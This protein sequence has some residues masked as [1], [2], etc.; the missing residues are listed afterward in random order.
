MKS[1]KV[2]VEWAKN[3]L[4]NHELIHIKTVANTDYSF[5][6]EMQCKNFCFFLKKNHMLF[7]YEHKLLSYLYLNQTNSLNVYDYNKD[8]NCFITEYNGIQIT[9]NILD[10][11]RQII[12]RFIDI[13]IKSKK[14]ELK[15]LGLR[16]FM[17]AE[18]LNLCNKYQV[19]S[20]NLLKCW[21]E[22]EKVIPLSL[23]HGDFHLGNI[24]L[25]KNDRITFI[26]LA[27]G[28]ITNPLFSLLAFENTLK[29]RGNLNEVIIDDARNYWIKK[30]SQK[31]QLDIDIV[32]KM[33]L[34]SKE[35]FPLYCIFGLDFLLKTCSDEQFKAKTN[36]KISNYKKLLLNHSV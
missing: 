21:N 14:I 18:I 10:Y 35:I 20:H 4:K 36:M 15:E 29:W 34:Y 31:I 8:L 17:E 6:A 22:I 27:E 3:I 19:K 12:D 33:Y 13:Q 11:Y 30:Y 24:L 25:D 5:V 1:I 2:E 9:H 7:N 23:E 28:T 16:K 26:D 32:K